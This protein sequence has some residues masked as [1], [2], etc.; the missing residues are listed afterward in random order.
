VSDLS[1]IQS[2]LERLFADRRIVVWSDPTGEFAADFAAVQITGVET[3]RVAN[4]EFQLK[5]RM[6]RQEAKRQFLIYRP[7]P[8]PADIDNWLLDIELAHARFRADK[9][10]LLIQQLG[11][12]GPVGQKIVAE[13][14]VFFHSNTRIEQLRELLKPGDNEDHIRA[15]MVAILCG[16]TEHRLLDI[17]RALL[18]ENAR[19]EATT[20]QLIVETGLAGF[21][22]QGAGRIYGYTSSN[23]S[24]DDF[25]LWLYRHALDGFTSDA[26]DGLRNIHLD[27]GTLRHD[28]RE[29]TTFQALARRVAA[30]LDVAVSIADQDFRELIDCD[31]F[32]VIDAKIVSDLANGIANRTLRSK[33]VA[34]LVRRCQVR[35]WFAEYAHLYAAIDAAAGFFREVD[36]LDASM[37]SF[38]DGL[39]QY[40]TRWYLIDQ[41]YRQFVLHARSAE[42]QGPLEQLRHTVEMYYSNKYLVALGGAWQ[43][44][45]DAL[46]SEGGRWQ[47]PTISSQTAFYAQHVEPVI[48]SGR[49]KMVV[50][51]SDA[52]RYEVAAELRSR[53]RQED[54]FD[55][56]LSHLVSVLPSYTQLGMAALLPHQKLEHAPGNKGLVLVDGKPSVGVHNR[57]KILA[58]VSGTAIQAEDFLK[59]S[60]DK[61]RELYRAHQVVY[62]YHNRIDE[63]GDNPK[64]EGRVF[65]ETEQAFAEIVD[66][67]KKLSNANATNIIVTADH[68]FL[69]Q[70]DGLD[71][72]DYL[73]TQPHGDE[74]L[75]CDRR[76]VLGKGLKQAPEFTTFTAAQLGL[77]G[78]VE[79]QIPKS[80]NRLRRHGSGS[81]FVHGGASLQ[82]VVVPVLTINKKR[83]G[84]LTK[85]S[86]EI[87]PESN[88]ITTGQISVKLFQQDAAS[89][90]VQ[91]RIVRAGLY[92]GEVLISNH[93]ELT[94]DL[95]AA[96]KRD[97]YVNVQLILSGEADE[98]N[99]RTVELRL[100]ERI[101][102]TNQW[103]TYKRVIYTL[104]RT[105]MS[106]FDF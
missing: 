16:Q 50:I 77:D 17:T 14:P 23:P 97:R 68:G 41:F 3:A 36:A 92:M 73:S 88:T 102:K 4:N 30:D 40:T 12:E 93:P 28:Y 7:G 70:D 37:Q 35:F 101:A 81:R 94:F 96:D 105:F 9:E 71:E 62:L 100:E 104:K 53:I 80:I 11:L 103:R 6:L 29:L 39:L 47:S 18:R 65:Q 38:D 8:Q 82:E 55:A 24:V 21:H 89:D 13:H 48:R 22:W 32:E 15:K 90:K 60:R 33:D 75:Y 67:V 42:H 106:D 57:R 51:V 43:K 76:F 69:Y 85:V 2:H 61:Q 1:R 34:E 79:V 99:N 63:T 26:P 44:Q 95:T 5:H 20:Y 52:L 56:D 84:D 46:V 78:D 45:V 19:G 98:H 64:S 54:R 49:K 83:S 25:V 10:S 87:L 72:S 58:S 31:L 66:L 91:P 86:V 74:I 27:F 59:L